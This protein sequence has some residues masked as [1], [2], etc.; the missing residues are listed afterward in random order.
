MLNQINK[1]QR[2]ILKEFRFGQKFPIDKRIWIWNHLNNLLA[3]RHKKTGFFRSLFFLSIFLK[4]FSYQ[5]EAITVNIYNFYSA[6][7]F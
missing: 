4:L 6:I 2:A 1:Y 5:P 3:T 7:L